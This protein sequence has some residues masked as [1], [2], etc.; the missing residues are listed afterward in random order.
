MLCRSERPDNRVPSEPVLNVKILGDIAVVIV[1]DKRVPIN[2]VIQRQR[3]HH[4][5]KAKD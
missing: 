5:E 3:Q 4:Q 1:I 2:R